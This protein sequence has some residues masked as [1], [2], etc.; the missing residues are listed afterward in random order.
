MR[1]LSSLILLSALATF[2]ATAW[3]QTAQQILEKSIQLDHER[4]RA[5]QNYTVDQSTMNHRVLIYYEKIEGV[6]DDGTPYSTFRQV[7]PAEIA[8]RQGKQEK[9]TPEQL[10]TFASKH[11]EVGAALSDEMNKSGMPAGILKAMGP[12]PGEEPWAS[13][14]PRVSHGAMA[15]FLRAAATAQENEPDGTAEAGE[16]ARQMREFA[17]AARYV[18]TET[19]DGQSAFH[20]RADDLNYTPP[21]PEDQRDELDGQQFTVNAVSLWLDTTQYVPLK[22]RMDGTVVAEGQLREMYI[23]KIDTDYQRFGSMYES[24]KQIMK[25]GGILSPEQMAEMREAQQQLD[26]F[27]SQLASM[28][29]QQR[30][31]ME[32]MV[33]PQIDMLR[34][35]VETGG[36]VVENTVHDI[37]VNAGLPDLY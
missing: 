15:D 20:L 12:P 35:M 17:A 21:V 32:R 13:P 22:M 2:P 4:K 34:N 6:A 23:E 28:P 24:K 37:K 27:D 3:S 36:F 8:E 30:Q 31:M 7:P 10:R 11:E 5:V 19:I 16:K 14:D 26:E 25:M 29:P 9:L 18:G 33:G 1:K